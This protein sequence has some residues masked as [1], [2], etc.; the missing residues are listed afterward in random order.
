MKD[1]YEKINSNTLVLKVKTKTNI[2]ST[3]KTRDTETGDTLPQEK[4]CCRL[5]S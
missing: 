5:Q 1:R 4:M 2:K 3:G